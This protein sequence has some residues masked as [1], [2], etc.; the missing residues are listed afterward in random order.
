VVGEA[1]E[2]RVEEEDEVKRAKN[3]L[4][5]EKRVENVREE[6]EAGGGK[7]KVTE[8]THEKTSERV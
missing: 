4:S 5:R 2:K 6:T 7:M 1:E 8:R 3:K